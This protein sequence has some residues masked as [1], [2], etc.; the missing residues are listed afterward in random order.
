MNRSS[1][2]FIDMI[3]ILR[4]VIRIRNGKLLKFKIFFFFKSSQ[5]NLTKD[6]GVVK[7]PIKTF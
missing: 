3:G 1:L 2:N 7:L 6:K 5:V 4:S